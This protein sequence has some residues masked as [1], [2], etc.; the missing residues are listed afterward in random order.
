MHETLDGKAIPGLAVNRRFDKAQ[1]L[2]I[3]RIDPLAK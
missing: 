2:P 3:E 1:D